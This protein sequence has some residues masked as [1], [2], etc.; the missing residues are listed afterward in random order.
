MLVGRQ[1]V[2]PLYLLALGIAE[3]NRCSSRL[4]TTCVVG[5]GDEA[6]Q[7]MFWVLLL[8]MV[9]LYASRPET[10]EEDAGGSWASFQVGNR[11]HAHRPRDSHRGELQTA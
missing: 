3:A 10:E 2:Q 9:A 11:H 6:V 5:L 8:T 1:A 4:V 7:S